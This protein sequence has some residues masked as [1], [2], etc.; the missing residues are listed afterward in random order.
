MVYFGSGLVKNAS[1]SCDGYGLC[2]HK[3]AENN[4]ISG[5]VCE[6]CSEFSSSVILAC[7]IFLTFDIE[8]SYYFSMHIVC[9][10]S[11]IL[12]FCEASAPVSL[13]IF[14]SHGLPALSRGWQHLKLSDVSLGTRRRYRLVVD[15]DVK[16]STK[17]T[18]K[19]LD[20]KQDREVTS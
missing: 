10:Y 7:S 3:I 12:L 15:E 14:T 16:K 8:Y 19:S 9:K 6:L 17:Q 4:I 18:K 20:F 2:S 13:I 5:H 1:F 11:A